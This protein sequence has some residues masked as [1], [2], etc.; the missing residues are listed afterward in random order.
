[1]LSKSRFIS[2]RCRLWRF[3]ATR[4]LTS[5]SR[6]NPVQAEPDDKQSTS[7]TLSSD[8]LAFRSGILAAGLAT[9]A[10][11]SFLTYQELIE[12]FLK[13][14]ISNDAGLGDC[15]GVLLWSTALFFASPI[16][17]LL[18]FLGKIDTERPSDWMIRIIRIAAGL[19]VDDP[20]QTHD[21]PQWIN[22]VVVAICVAQGLV[23]TTLLSSSLG[24]SAWAIASGLGACFAG[25]IYEAGRPRR[26]EKEESMTL[27]AQW[28]D[29]NHW[30]SNRLQRKGNCHETEI[31]EAFR[32]E[33]A[34][35]RS[36]DTISDEILRDM[37]RNWGRQ[38]NYGSGVE[39]TSRGFIKGISVLARSD[40][41]TGERRGIEP[42]TL[43]SSVEG[44]SIEPAAG[45]HQET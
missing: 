30:S 45:Y 44:S 33:N 41:F 32:R 38:S 29:F 34:R 17:L 16:Q 31:F 13:D 23:I 2:G 3:S 6:Q 21:A 8:V 9:C 14:V 43:P 24:D 42:P 22:L 40:P 5:K 10:T 39:R 27:E 25:A 26:L 11:L 37:I 20:G 28:V 18:L 1:M 19:P 12:D 7:K 15:L 36:M 35:Y 4:H